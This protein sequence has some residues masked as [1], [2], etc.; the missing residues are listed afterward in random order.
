MLGLE[1]RMGQLWKQNKDLSVNHMVTLVR[2]AGKRYHDSESSGV[3]NMWSCFRVYAA[4]S[5]VLSLWGSEGFML[6][7]DSTNRC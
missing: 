5:Y 6:N 2:K 7:L 1:K 4:A 3:K